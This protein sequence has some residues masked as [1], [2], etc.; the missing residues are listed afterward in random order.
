L[1][2]PDHSRIT[3]VDLAR[4]AGV[5]PSTVSRA[6]SGAGNLTAETRTR[7]EELAR[8]TGYV[9]NHGARMMRSRR[10]SQI[11]LIVPNIAASFYPEVILGVEDAIGDRAIGV[12]VGSTQYREDREDALARQLL[13][14]AADGLL[15]MAG[16]LPRELLEMPLY[17]QRA[18]AIARPFPNSRIA[19]VTIDNR[20]A[21]AEATRHLISLGR[22]RI[23][24]IAGPEDSLVFSARVA[25]FLEAMTEAGLRSGAEISYLPSFDVAAGRQGMLDIMDRGQLPDAILCTTDEIAFGAIQIARQSGILVPDDLAFIGFDDHAISAAFEPA[26]TTIA[27]PR[28]QMGVMAAQML[29]NALEDDQA[30]P[31]DQIVPYRLIVRRS[32]GAAPTD[33]EL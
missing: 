13:T 14:G 18:I 31:T 30:P 17:R 27:I 29:F 7:I 22:R 2:T 15:I 28:R 21:A 23:L 1:A 6:L 26:L 3:I 32:C 4:M 33:R 9:A 10:S 8:K 20:A 24:H 5:S 11:L 25:G 16:R 19:A 12:V